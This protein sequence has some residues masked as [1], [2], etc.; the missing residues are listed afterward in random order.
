MKHTSSG[1]TLVEIMTVV[2]I[3]GILLALAI[4]SYGAYRKS[5]QKKQCEVNMRSIFAAIEEARLERDKSVIDDIKENGTITPL[6]NGTTDKNKKNRYL[7]HN[8]VCPTKKTAYEIE[9]DDDTDTYK[10]KCTGVTDHVLD[11]TNDK[12]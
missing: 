8:V 12:L 7:P 9:Y 3:I 4:P 11:K 2:L 5:A 1:Y 10:V 6:V